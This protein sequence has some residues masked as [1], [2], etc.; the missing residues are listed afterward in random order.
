MRA[1]I[2]FKALSET[3]RI[4]HVTRIQRDIIIHVH[5][6]AC[7]STHYS[8]QMLLQPERFVGIYLKRS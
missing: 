8:C 5:T 1:L 6:S 2:F 4:K 7:K 3:F